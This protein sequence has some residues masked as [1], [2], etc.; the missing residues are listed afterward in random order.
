MIKSDFSQAVP[1]RLG[2]VLERLLAHPRGGL[3]EADRE[4]A[5]ARAVPGGEVGRERAGLFVDEEV[6]LALA[7]QRD[8]LRA[9][10]GDR[11]EPEFREQRVQHLRIGRRELDELETVDTHRV[12]ERGDL[13]AEVGLGVHLLSVLRK[14]RR[15]GRNFV[16][17]IVDDRRV[18]LYSFI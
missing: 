6:A 9:M 10:L 12:L 15:R 18:L 13:H 2:A 5:R 16:H 14:L 8:V 3:L 7:I 4:P 11:G 1:D 17:A